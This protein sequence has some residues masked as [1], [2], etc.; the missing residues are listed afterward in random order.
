MARA[1]AGETHLLL[2]AVQDTCR[3]GTRAETATS[4]IQD[5]GVGFDSS[6]M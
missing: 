3:T 5:G 4:A 6:V 2:N 1:G